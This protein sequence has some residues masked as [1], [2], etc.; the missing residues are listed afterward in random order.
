LRAFDA[1]ARLGG[2]RAAAQALFVTPGAVTQQ[3]RALEDYLG[4]TVVE[5]QG[6]AIVLTEAGRALYLNTTRHLRAIA[7]AAD[8]VRPRRGRVR[9]TT[10]HSVAV[11]WLVPRLRLF[12]LAQP[13]IEVLVDANPQLVDLNSG[14]WD[15]GIREGEGRYQGAHCEPLFE[16]AVVPV[17]SPAYLQRELGGAAL[18]W[19]HARLLHEVGHPW[20]QR[21]LDMAQ[22]APAAEVAVERGLFFSH[23]AMVVAAAMDG[24]GVALVAPFLIQQELEDHK[25][26]VLDARPLATGLGIYAVW[27]ESEELV[28]AAVRVFRQWL[29]AEAAGDRARLEQM[30]PP[31]PAPAPLGAPRKRRAQGV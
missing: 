11:R 18:R 26:V 16:L 8:S 15:L 12:S 5:R 3:L 23:T 29:V 9:V 14:S 27:P 2:V 10:V 28:P 25:L 24:Q 31:Q 17:A 13:D 30:V 19:K 21:W 1:V 6:R 4:I 22:V 20:W 7:S